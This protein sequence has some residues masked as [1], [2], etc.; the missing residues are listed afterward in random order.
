[1]ILVAFLSGCTAV[2]RYAPDNFFDDD[3]YISDDCGSDFELLGV[4]ND[5]NAHVSLDSDFYNYYV[6]CDINVD[7]SVESCNESY[8]FTYNKENNSHVGR[9]DYENK[10]CLDG[11]DGNCTLSNDCESDEVC[12]FSMN[13]DENTHIGNCSSS[14]YDLLCCENI[15]IGSGNGNY[16]GNGNGDYDNCT[17]SDECDAHADCPSRTC[18][19]T[20]CTCEPLVGAGGCSLTD[21]CDAHGDCPGG[22]CDWDTCTCKPAGCTDLDECDEDSDCVSKNCDISTCSCVGMDVEKL[23]L[24]ILSILIPLILVVLFL[25]VMA[26][27]YFA[28]RNKKPKI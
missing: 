5:F 1:M 28:G 3:C 10:F 6:C 11:Y 14:D 2:P 26:V 4:S 17:S 21:E 18:D 7:T 12:I 13:S 25:G 9:G 8:L 27:F 20:T 19:F 24:G 16:N 22:L 23:D 15:G